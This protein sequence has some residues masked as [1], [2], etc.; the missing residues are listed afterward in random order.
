MRF[1]A[2]D[3]AMNMNE[4][5]E[6]LQQWFPASR[7]EHLKWAFI[8]ENNADFDDEW[9]EPYYGVFIRYRSPGILVQPNNRP[10]VLE[11]ISFRSKFMVR[12][13]FI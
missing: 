13:I 3:H 12:K 4:S 5:E 7:Q 11:W 9:N 1:W 6:G 2:Q 8:I 10:G